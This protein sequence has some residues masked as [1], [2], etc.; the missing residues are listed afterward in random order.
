[1]S[2]TTDHK[3]THKGCNLVSFADIDQKVKLVVA[4]HCKKKKIFSVG[5]N[6]IC[7]LARHLRNH[8]TDLI[9]LDLH[10]QLKR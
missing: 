2:Q 10:L 6:P 4:A 9:K 3:K 7:L 1:M 8:W 5:L